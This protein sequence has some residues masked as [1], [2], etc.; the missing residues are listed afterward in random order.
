MQ[1]IKSNKSTLREINIP[2]NILDDPVIQAFRDFDISNAEKQQSNNLNYL[3]VANVVFDFYSF[4]QKQEIIVFIMLFAL[5]Q[6]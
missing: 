2:K 5:L 1:Q 4:F 3:Y 6:I